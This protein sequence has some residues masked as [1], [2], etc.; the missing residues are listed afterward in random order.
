MKILVYRAV[1]IPTLLY[2]AETRFLYKKQTKLLK[3]F[4]LR[5]LRS[6]LRIKWL[7]YVSN[8]KVFKRASLPS[9][10]SI[11]LQAPL[12][13]A[14]HVSRME[15]IRKHKAV[16]FSQLKGGKRNRGAP[17]KRYKDQLAHAGISNGSWQHEISDR[18]SWRSS[19]SQF[20]DFNVLSTA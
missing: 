17:R 1:I 18:D 3:W 20:L 12:R 4:H 11:L 16:F 14:G 8:V 2:G 10:E 6:T 19:V 15:D 5:C 13:L 9:I 7:D